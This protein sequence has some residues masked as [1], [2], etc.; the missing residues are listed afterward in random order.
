MAGMHSSYILPPANG[1][2]II[3][4]NN[5]IFKGF[6]NCIVIDLASECITVILDPNEKG[7]IREKVYEEQNMSGIHLIVSTST[8]LPLV[9]SILTC[10]SVAVP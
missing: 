5:G 8:I 7:K 10:N 9:A 3:C 6:I 1:A 2:T 4:Y